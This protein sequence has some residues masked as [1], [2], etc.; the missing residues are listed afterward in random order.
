MPNSDQRVQRLCKRTGRG[1]ANNQN[2]RLIRCV[3]NYIVQLK[4]KKRVCN[5][6]E[7]NKALNDVEKIC[8]E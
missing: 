6:L 1:M 4:K 8:Q 2:I 3:E 7:V 5:M